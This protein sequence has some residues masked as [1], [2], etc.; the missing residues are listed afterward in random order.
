VG[1]LAERYD[2]L[3]LDL[4]GVVYRGDRPLDGAPATID[5]VSQAGGRVSFLTNNYTLTPE[6][7]AATIESFVRSAGP[8]AFLTCGHANVPLVARQASSG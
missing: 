6:I 1:S 4:D 5:E 2:A 8:D 7:V 3:L